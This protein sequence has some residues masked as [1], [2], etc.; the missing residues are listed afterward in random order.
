MDFELSEEQSLI[1]QTARE[2]A[3][4]EVAPHIAKFDQ[5]AEF[6]YDI[7]TKM[8]G[9]GF[10]GLP[11]PEEYGGAG[12][13]TLSYALAVEEISRAD[14]STGITMAAHVSLGTMP[15]VLFGS[16]A[17]K[18]EYIPS[19]AAGEKLWAFGLTEPNAG[20][21]A[22]ATETRA[23]LEDG[24]WT[25]DGAKSFITN[26]GTRITGGVT[27]T[28]VTGSG[29]D[30]KPEIS[31]LIVPSGTP[32]LHV[33]KDYHKMGWRSSDTHELSFQGA[34]VPA[35]NILGERGHGFRQFL[36]ILDGG[37]ISVAALSVG[38]A[39]ACLDASL[40]YAKE[41]F[42]FG[43][44][45][46]SFEAVQFKLADMATAIEHARLMTYKAAWL[47]DQGKDFA[48][49]AGM[50]KL[51]ASRVATMAADEA[52]QIHGGYGIMEEYP[53]ARYWRDVKIGEIG[54]GTS[55]IQRLVIAKML[56]L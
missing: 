15:F 23:S 30:G 43:R 18:R 35:G 52:V 5:R 51:Y 55:E 26:S 39:Q 3:Q 53:V 14:A 7:V 40:K 42:Q 45:I 1:Q 24:E 10:L 4:A 11:I 33:A 20:S 32:G 22:G 48:M 17:Q 38:L 29:S 31:N 56:G 44:S 41:R 37:R 16:E 19:L 49:T 21:D 46:G 54:E 47:K 27:I 25:I 36:T 50:A 9:L 8:A 12:A 2:F 28:A 13:D 34:R 6:P